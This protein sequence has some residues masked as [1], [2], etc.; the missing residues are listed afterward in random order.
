M[1]TRILFAGLVSL[2][3]TFPAAA[4]VVTP[5][6]FQVTVDTSSVAGTS[7]SFM[8]QAG[9][10]GGTT[11]PYADQV[12]V[13]NLA[14]GAT[15]VTEETGTEIGVKTIS[16]SA[17]TLTV[18]SAST[19]AQY[20]YDVQ[21]FG[22]TLSFDVTLSG[23]DFYGQNPDTYDN[24]F[25]A[26]TMVQNQVNPYGGGNYSVSILTD[27]DPYSETA[28]ITVDDNGDLASDAS[29]EASVTLV[30]VPEPTS[31]CALALGA[32]GLLRKKSRRRA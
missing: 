10:P 32:I 23:G 24:T 18:S 30:P 27:N 22:S 19:D 29:S 3:A 26:L 31:L 5:Q 11:T 6:T 15:G 13:T 16:H 9:L 8:F 20:I 1:K 2:A 28:G 7:G 21:K 14:P 12:E 17:F 4:S 25:F